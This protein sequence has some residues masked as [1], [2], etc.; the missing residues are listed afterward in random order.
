MLNAGVALTKKYMTE[1]GFELHMASNHFGH[2]LLT[3]LL[4]P[5]LR[6]TAADNMT[7]S[8][9]GSAEPR[10]VDPV[11][12]VAVSSIA[13]FYANL[14]LDNLNSEKYYDVSRSS[15]ISFS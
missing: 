13:H 7:D 2:F 12:V 14:E 9:N 1:D 4:L 10:N 5:L 3:N 11:R 6:R 8:P 15:F